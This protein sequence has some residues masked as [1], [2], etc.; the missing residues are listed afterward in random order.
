MKRYDF[1]NE[2]VRLL[3]EAISAYSEQ[4]AVFPDNEGNEDRMWKMGR[5]YQL[6]S[7]PPDTLNTEENDCSIYPICDY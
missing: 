7:S 4:C 6:L 2:Q 3:K 1:T 5:L